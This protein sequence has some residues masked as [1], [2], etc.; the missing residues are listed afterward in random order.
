MTHYIFASDRPWALSAFAARR[1]QLP[2]HWSIVT[3]PADLEATLAVT[4]PRYVFFPHWSHIVPQNVLD[5]VECVCFH[6]ADVPYGRGGSPLQ[7]LIVRG[8]RETKLTALKMSADLDAGPV[9]CKVPM[10]LEGSATKI[11][12]RS[13]AACLDLIAELIATTPKPM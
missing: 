13:A 5:T 4:E 10:S 12:E 8:H 7:N 9:Y 11:F 1:P 6:M 2:G 3:S